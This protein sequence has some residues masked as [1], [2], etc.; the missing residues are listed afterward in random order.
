MRARMSYQEVDEK[1][2][3]MA[4]SLDDPSWYRPQADIYT[5]SAQPW[6]HMNPD[7]PKFLKLLPS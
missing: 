4:G 1:V 3:I 7:L 6:D 2:S 5:A